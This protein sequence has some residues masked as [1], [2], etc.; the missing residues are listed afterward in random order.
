ML[1]KQ[2]TRFLLALLILSCL[3]LVADSPYKANSIYGIAR[4]Y[5]FSVARWEVEHFFNKWCREIRDLYGGH[6]LSREERIE[7]AEK[8]FGLQQEIDR[9]ESGLKGA[10]AAST[11]EQRDLEARLASLRKEQAGDENRVEDILEAQISGVLADE[12]LTLR[13]IWKT[14]LVIPPVDF[15]FAPLPHVLVVSPRYEIRAIEKLPLEPKLSPEEIA[16]IEARVEGLGYSALVTTVSGVATYPSLVS[17]RA[18]L[19]STLSLVAHEWLHQY[20]FLRPL[21][22]H[23]GASYLM[24]TINETAASMAGSELASL[25]FERYGGEDAADGVER[26]TAFDFNRAMRDIRRAVDRYLAQGEI[27]AAESFMEEQRQLLASHGY[28][29]RRLNQAYFAF[30]GSYADSP[31]SISPIGGQLE[32][33]RQRS[34][35]LGGFVRAVAQISSYRDLAELLERD[36]GS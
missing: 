20:F 6:D 35:S 12:G 30:H 3:T 2:M 8:Y 19:E 1:R 32:S 33:L 7:L 17:Q 34:A 22:R 36:E 23:Y 21:G 27:E 10:A 18:S 5:I 11:D 16:E 4:P 25:V 15:E 24:T 14:G 26:E 29:I 13:L 9:L 31:T 28:S